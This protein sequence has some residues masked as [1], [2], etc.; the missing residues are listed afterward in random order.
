MLQRER[1]RERMSTV[2]LDHVAPGLFLELCLDLDRAALCNAELLEVL[3]REVGHSVN[4]HLILDQLRYDTIRTT[5]ISEDDRG[6]DRYGCYSFAVEWAGA[7]VRS[8][9]PFPR[10]DSAGLTQ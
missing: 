6:N 1:E 2:L 4:A 9:S 5:A 10:N 7:S 8:L 3:A